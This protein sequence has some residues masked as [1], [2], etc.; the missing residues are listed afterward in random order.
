MYCWVLVK[1]GKK[2]ECEKSE[3]CYKATELSLFEY[4]KYTSG[5]IFKKKIEEYFGINDA[6]ENLNDIEGVEYDV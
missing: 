6:L 1:E 2:K 5:E 4:W 3:C